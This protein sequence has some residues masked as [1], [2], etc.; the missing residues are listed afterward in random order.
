[1]T[2]QFRHRYVRPGHADLILEHNALPP[3]LHLLRTALRIPLGARMRMRLARAA[4]RLKVLSA[5]QIAQ[6]D[7]QTYSDWRREQG[8]D[9]PFIDQLAEFGA[10]ACAFL[11]TEDVSAYTLLTWMRSMSASRQLSAIAPFP[12]PIS[13]VLIQPL[14]DRLLRRGVELLFGCAA[15]DLEVRQRRVSAV[16]L[17]ETQERSMFSAPDGAPQLAG[18]GARRLKADWVIS[19][20]PVQALA[21]LVPAHEAAAFGL[22]RLHALR[23]VPALSAVVYF[24]RDIRPTPGGVALASGYRVRDFVDLTEIWRSPTAAPGSIYQLLMADARLHLHLDDAAI[25]AAML[26][27]LRRAWRPVRE[28]RP[29]AW[30]VQR[31]GAAMFAATP[32]AYDLRPAPTT[33]L[34]NLFLAGDWTRHDFNASMEGAVFSG[35]R[36]ARE[37]RQRLEDER[38]LSDVC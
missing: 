11:S 23:T 33:G 14:V 1:L 20:L 2:W 24:D 35:R 25:V 31:V 29:V 15:V 26:D 36:A 8:L 38:R 34:E 5:A 3:P 19:A 32:G 17:R 18:G 37:V 16:L 9:S 10:D 28:A 12:G 6:L 7:S 30:T 4:L 22:E 27:D 13:K 21:R